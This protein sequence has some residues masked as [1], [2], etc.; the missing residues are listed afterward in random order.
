MEK[1]PVEG[2]S[3]T[4]KGSGSQP[5]QE[6]ELSGEIARKSCLLNFCYRKRVLQ[7]HATFCNL[8]KT[9]HFPFRIF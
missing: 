9:L 2:D 8:Q 6:P 7:G 4:E 1:S 5:L 3:E